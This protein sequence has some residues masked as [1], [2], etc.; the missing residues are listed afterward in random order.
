[1]K[2]TNKRQVYN[3]HSLPQLF[4]SYA[5]PSKFGRSLIYR[6]LT[7]T[8]C[9]CGKSRIFVIVIYLFQVVDMG[10]VSE[11]IQ[12][13]ENYNITKEALEVLYTSLEA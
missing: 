7:C 13:L 5:P 1:M 9:P 10:I 6:P 3:S 2:R 8:S 4:A 11:V 12:E